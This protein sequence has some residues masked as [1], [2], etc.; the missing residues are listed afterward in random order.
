MP[1]RLWRPRFDFS[2][3]L[4]RTDVCCHCLNCWN[5]SADSGVD[6]LPTTACKIGFRTHPRRSIGPL[7]NSDPRHGGILRRDSATGEEMP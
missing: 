1:S 2:L 7:W 3:Y 4:R 5:C 6:G